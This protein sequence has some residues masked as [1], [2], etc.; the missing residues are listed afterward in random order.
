[1]FIQ[2]DGIEAHPTRKGKYRIHLSNGR[3]LILPE[4]V[5]INHR[6][7]P[8]MQIT[9]EEVATYTQEVDYYEAYHKALHYLG[10]RVRSCLEMRMY[11][12][13]K[14]I[15]PDL[16][17]VIVS[18]LIDKGLLDDMEFAD[19]L[20]KDR[21]MGKPTGKRRLKHELET[22]GVKPE[23]VNDI[24]GSITEEEELIQAVRMAEKYYARHSRKEHHVLKAA[25]GQTL[26]RQGFDWEIIRLA[27]SKVLIQEDEE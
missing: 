16:I 20:V 9:K 22:K 7:V 18:K 23:I 4:D 3:S 27:L 15:D 17:E 13:R 1:M 12:K 14:R 19:K 26:Q 24:V 5:L 21:R 6:L 11:L 8:G 25:I 10:F 2:I